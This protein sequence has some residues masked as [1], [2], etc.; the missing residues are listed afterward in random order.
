MVFI[1]HGHYNEVGSDYNS[2]LMLSRVD[3]IDRFSFIG[4]TILGRSNDF[5]IQ[6]VD[7][8]TKAITHHL[9][10]EQAFA[11]QFYYLLGNRNH[12]ILYKNL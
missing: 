12:Y 10:C 2:P 4:S 3:A 5:S 6:N 11:L 8:F 9:C 7:N 1:L